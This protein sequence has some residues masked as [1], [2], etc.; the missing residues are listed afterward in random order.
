MAHNV[1]SNKWVHRIKVL[2]LIT[3]SDRNQHRRVRSE[4]LLL[5]RIIGDATV[6]SK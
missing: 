1:A 5:G 2:T 4:L 3:A 6:A